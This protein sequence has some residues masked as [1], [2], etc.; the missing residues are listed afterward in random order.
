M[1]ACNRGQPGHDRQSEDTVATTKIPRGNEP[2]PTLNDFLDAEGAR[3]AFQAFAIK[4]G[5]AWQI[6]PAM[7][8]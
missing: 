6:E 5:L 2:F 4:E 8:S 1:C 7:K 3:E